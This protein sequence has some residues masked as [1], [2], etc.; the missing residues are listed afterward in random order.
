MQHTAAKLV[1]RTCKHE[2][3]TPVLQRLH[4]QPVCELIDYK[5]LLLVFQGVQGLTPG[6]LAELHVQKTDTGGPPF[7]I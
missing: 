6:Y 3:I 1:T 4:W 2:C 7:D 5:T